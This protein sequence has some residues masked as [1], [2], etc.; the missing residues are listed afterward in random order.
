MA[1][2]RNGQHELVLFDNGDTYTGAWRNDCLHGR[3]TY[4][5]ADGK[6]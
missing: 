3:G 1:A 5:W 2:Q 6:R 4:I